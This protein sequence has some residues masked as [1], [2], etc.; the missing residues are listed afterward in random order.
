MTYPEPEAY[1]LPSERD[2]LRRVLLSVSIVALAVA[3]WLSWRAWPSQTGV[4]MVWKTILSAAVGFCLM[5]VMYYFTANSGGS[6]GL[7]F[8]IFVIIPLHVFA[9]VLGWLTVPLFCPGAFAMMHLCILIVLFL[10]EA[11]F[12]VFA[13]W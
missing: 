1:E 11:A 2:F 8:M 13:S 9:A 7:G 10:I 12:L 6:G 3:A 4:E 5:F